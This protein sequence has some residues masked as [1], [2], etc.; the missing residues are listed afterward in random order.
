MSEVP[1]GWA[2]AT[3]AEVSLVL[4]GYGFP[5][6][7]QGNSEGDLPF[8]KVGDI[9]EAW[10]R[11]DSFLR[12][13]EH[14]L[15]LEEAE[16]LKARP[17]PPGTT[18]FAKIGAAIG[19]NRRALLSEPS[20]VDNNMMGLVP[21]ADLIRDKYLFHYACTL[22]LMEHAQATTVPSV[23]KTDIEGLPIPV[24]PISEQDRIVAEIEKQFTRLD[25]ATAALK[26]VQANLKRYRASVLKAACEGRLVPTKAE[27]AREEGR[28]YEPASELLKRIL[29][30]RRAR[31][32]AD[33]LAKMIA[34]RKRPTDDRWKDKYKEPSLP[35]T[36]AL[37]D[38]PEGW[39]W[40]SVEMISTKVVDGVHKKPNYVASGI[41]F[42]TVRNLTAGPGISFDRTSFITAEDHAEFVKRADPE[43][44][45]ILISKDGTLGT[46]KAIRT[47]WA[48]SIFVSVAMVK[49]VL[50]EMSDYIE[51]ALMSSQVQ[52]QMA[53]KGSG[54]QHI[55][56]EDLREDCIPL[57]PLLEQTRIAEE[58]SKR[59]SILDDFEAQ[60]P[61]A[62]SR[63]G[64]LRNSILAH[65]FSGQLV[66]QDPTDEPAS[67]LLDRLRSE[68]AGKPKQRALRKRRE[69]AHA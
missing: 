33:T 67:V 59:L 41:P 26:R 13:A 36:S 62:F 9:S 49:P 58:C 27:L 17:F 6:H 8:Y 21:N 38:L 23:R 2:G 28:D 35:A 61:R 54:L 25:A 57:P 4:S 50:R 46:V 29:R 52:V 30:E 43:F 39:C 22:R 18:V 64:A 15:S 48:F 34:C 45:D 42:I 47:D 53:P 31:W 20:L 56:L 65:A 16:R 69:L 7:L 63:G 32:E 60:I 3:L 24:A 19:L 40:A 5:E 1:N 68:R 14:Y 66:S 12:R 10:K 44:G 51:I 37:P 55:H 11:G